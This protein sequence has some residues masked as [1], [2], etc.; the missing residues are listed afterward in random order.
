MPLTRLLSLGLSMLKSGIK[1]QRHALFQS[2]ENRLKQIRLELVMTW[3][4]L[5]LEAKVSEK[6]C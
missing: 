6:F 5:Q 1:A 3:M 4:S 2:S